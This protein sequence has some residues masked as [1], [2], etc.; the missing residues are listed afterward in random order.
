[1]PPEI[2]HLVAREHAAR[3]GKIF[4]RSGIQNLD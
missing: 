3:A 4:L 2:D 1:V